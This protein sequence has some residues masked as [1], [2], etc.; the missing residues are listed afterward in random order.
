MT[1]VVKAGGHTY[2]ALDQ[3]AAAQVLASL[4]TMRFRFNTDQ[5]ED[6]DGTCIPAPDSGPCETTR[7]VRVAVDGFPVGRFPNAGAWIDDAK[8]AGYGVVIFDPVNE[9]GGGTSI[10]LLATR[11]ARYAA[12]FTLGGASIHGSG[13]PGNVLF[14]PATGWVDALGACPPGMVSLPGGNCQMSP[15]D[16]HPPATASNSSRWLLGVALVGA[17]AGLA[18]YSSRRN[19]R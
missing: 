6:H 12:A 1:T 9:I 11:H 5:G 14:A 7:D 17:V 19:D 18:L 2:R 3:A 4:R 10:P 8:G 15:P 13:A 16:G